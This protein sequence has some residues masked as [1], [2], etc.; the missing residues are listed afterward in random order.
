MKKAM[1]VFLGLAMLVTMAV[2]VGAAPSDETTENEQ[3]EVTPRYSFTNSTKTYISSKIDD[4][5]TEVLIV[6]GSVTGYRGITTKIIID[7]ELQKLEGNDWVTINNWSQTFNSHRGTLE[8]TTFATSGTYR[9][10]ATYTVFGGDEC[11]IIGSS[12]L[13][14]EFVNEP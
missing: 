10:F 12:S 4:N 13:P 1:S 3:I 5:N 9:T 11:E 2:S 6:Q 8:Q 7:L 14:Y